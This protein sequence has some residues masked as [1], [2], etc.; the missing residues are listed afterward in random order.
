MIRDLEV[1]ETIYESATT[2]VERGFLSGAPAVIKSL[3]PS[4]Y[5]PHAISRYRHEYAINQT[6]TSPHARRALAFDEQET[7]I[8]FEDRGSVTLRSLIG[9]EGLS[10]DAKLTLAMQLCTAIQSIHDEGVIHRDINPANVLV[11]TQNMDVEIIDFGLATLAQREYPT[12]SNVAKLAGTLPYVSPEQTGRV[13]R[14]VDHRTDLYSLGATLYELFS[15][16]PPFASKDPLELIHFHIARSP[17]PLSE[18]PSDGPPWISD[19]VAKLLAKQPELRYQSA[20]AVR[21]DIA[22]ARAAGTNV[23]SFQLGRSDSPGQLA[24]PKKL[25][26]RDAE[27]A[28]VDQ[29]VEQ[30]DRGDS[31]LMQISGPRGVGKAAFLDAISFRVAERDAVCVRLSDP[32]QDWRAFEIE[33]LKEVVRHELSVED[34]EL[35]QLVGSL[36][37]ADKR[38]ID[39]YLPELSAVIGPPQT[40]RSG[41]PLSLPRVLKSTDR[42][43]AVIIENIDNINADIWQALV[44]LIQKCKRVFVATSSAKPIPMPS[45]TPDTARYKHH[46]I[47]LGVITAANIRALLADMLSLSESRVRELA[48]DVH[49]KTGGLPKHVFDLLYELHGSGALFFERA[50]QQWQW[51]IGQVRGHYFSDSTDERVEHQIDELPNDTRT[52]LT[53]ATGLGEQFTLGI[54]ATI[55]DTPSPTAARA[56]REALQRGLVTNVSEDVTHVLSYRF[57]H[58]RVRAR[59]YEALG[60][61]GRRR[62]HTHIAEHLI[63]DAGE[64]RDFRTI[65][66]HMNAATDPTAIDA[67]RLESL[68]HHNLVAAREAMR[69]RSFQAA[70]KY[71]RSAILV[72]ADD[73]ACARAKAELRELAAQASFLCGDFDQLARVL[74][75]P[76][77]EDTV[78]LSLI[79]LRAALACNELTLA[80]GIALRCLDRLGIDLPAVTRFGER[81]S[82]TT[83]R[84]T[85]PRVGEAYVVVGK[86]LHL[87]YL[88]RD[89]SL[90]HVA[91]ALLRLIKAHGAGP[92][93]ALAFACMACTASADR[94]L[95]QSEQYADAAL[96]AGIELPGD[97]ADFARVLVHGV[98]DPLRAPIAAVIESLRDDVDQLVVNQQYENAATA[99][100]TYALTRY[101][102]GSELNALIRE[103]ETRIDLFESLGFI[104]STNVGAYLVS[105]TQSITGNETS[106][107]RVG[108]EISN[109]DDIYARSVVYALRLHYAVLWGDFHGAAELVATHGD[110]VGGLK[111]T[112]IGILVEFCSA[113]TDLKVTG[114]RQLAKKALRR[115]ATLNKRGCQLSTPKSWM[116]RAELASQVGHTSEALDHFETAAAEARK[117]NLTHDEALAYE[118]G[119]RAAE[120]NSRSDFARLLASNAYQAYLRWGATAKAQAL[121][122]DFRNIQSS[123]VRSRAVPSA[124]MSDFTVRDFASI[125][126]SIDSAEMPGHLGDAYLDT[127]TVLR[128]AQTIASEIVLD[129]VL[130]RLLHLVLEHAG[131]QR[132]CMLLNKEHGLELEAVASV[133]EGQSKRLVPSIPQE[134]CDDIPTGVVQFVTHSKRALVLDDASRENLFAGDAY[135][136]RVKPQSVMCVPIL[137]HGD[138]TGVL[139][140]EHRRL[141]DVFDSERVEV[142]SLLASQSAIAIE[143]A[144]LYEDLESARDEYRTLYDGANEGLF[145]ITPAGTLARSNPA[146]ARVLGF[147]DPALLIEEYRDLIHRVFLREHD[148]R[149]FLDELEANGRVN[150][151]EAEGVTRDGSTF[152]MAVSARLS[153]DPDRGDFIDGSVVDIT[154]RVEREKA[155]QERQIAEAA[156][157]AKSEFLATMSHEIRTPMNAIIGFSRL[158]LETELDRKQHEYMVSIRNAS[159]AL[160][161]LI[162]DVLDFSKIEAGKLDL[163][164]APFHLGKLIDDVERLLRTEIR[165]KGLEFIVENRAEVEVVVGD[166]LRFRQVLIN[167]LGNAMKFTT[168]GFIRVDI[169]QVRASDSSVTLAVSVADSGIGISAEQQARLFQSFEQAESS[170]TRRFGGTGLGLAI[171]KQLVTMMDGD[172]S[173]VSEPGAGAQFTCTV[174]FGLTSEDVAVVAETPSGRRASHADRL[175]GLNVLLAEDNPI[176]QQLALEFLQRAGAT[177]AIAAT[178]TEAVHQASTTDFDIVFMDIHMPEMD[179][180]TATRKLRE[181][182]YDVPIVAVSADALEERKQ[183]AL[184]AGCNAYITKPI[185]IDALI[186]AVEESV[187]IK[188][189]EGDEAPRRRASDGLDSDR[190]IGDFKRV[191]GI[192][193]GLAIKNHN[194]NVGLMLRLMGDFGGYYGDAAQ[195]MRDYLQS[196]AFE[197]AE[198]LAHNLHGVAGSFGANRLKDA[199]KTLENALVEGDSPNLIGLVQSF[200]IALTEVLE[201]CEAI[202]RQEVPLRASDLHE[203][204]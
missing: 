200:E 97:A 179:G 18:M 40:P 5:S 141:S 174:Q 98:I 112:P 156:T 168:H 182:G 38:E 77:S 111:G 147:D 64:S 58:P 204:V 31:Q 52:L 24:I 184:D 88:S 25:Y 36:A 34:P 194:D 37:N 189:D 172:V 12:A 153:H 120:R 169:D 15:G 9:A 176:N 106:E 135:I 46:S 71:C 146:L 203:P 4:A 32:P 92:E 142:V 121:A 151:L 160:I 123:A 145:R 136:E 125:S 99:F 202:A 113:M 188:S 69:E 93:Q 114:S 144:R 3:K 60:E 49:S 140:I 105:F 138:I 30:F 19:I 39:D 87:A 163:E 196:E 83:R 130:D 75:R 115:F 90:A 81:F 137:A 53:H 178:G 59:L 7:R 192:D 127:A 29:A 197:D 94:K 51:D 117:H 14:V 128:A 157:E 45:E 63:N 159:E 170:T 102:A 74:D 54:L 177:V 56:L 150:G 124:S 95:K 50:H 68:V 154:Q 89:D 41:E 104:T 109:P 79:E 187:E 190:R 116:L 21:A 2:L 181:R 191:H 78:G 110:E 96:T 134:K 17:T 133:D 132:A 67:E 65:A 72:C 107:A 22:D 23:V 193:I 47:E 155:D 161:D 183:T 26:G 152:W 84:V 149:R 76:E 143:N 126:V 85:D 42:A 122:G 162:N 62:L 44:R 57:A 91:P 148:A 199:S 201:S 6:L 16:T 35:E 73:P 180:L 48:G 33:L 55:S 8:I 28:R 108:F 10:E 43:L 101:L 70:Y 175:L 186:F 13:N 167:L 86:L 27:F 158:A 139:Y 1:L 118:L 82:V 80:K 173:V 166:G 11:D 185:D 164:Q 195:K 100:A 66:D 20:D 61:D 171:V 165:K 119:A 103:T 198:R 129:R 131:A